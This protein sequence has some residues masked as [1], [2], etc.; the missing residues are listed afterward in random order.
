MPDRWHASYHQFL[1]S[2]TNLDLQKKFLLLTAGNSGN[3]CDET[4]NLVVSRQRQSFENQGIRIDASLDLRS[5]L[6]LKIV[7]MVACPKSPDASGS[8]KRIISLASFRG[9]RWRR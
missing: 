1:S 9:H 5:D 7:A 6:N 8:S 4:Q 2:V 3:M